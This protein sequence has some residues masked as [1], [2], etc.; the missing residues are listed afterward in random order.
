M[1]TYFPL[2][3]NINPSSALPPLTIVAFAFC[4]L[5]HRY[6][7]RIIPATPI[8]ILSH[9][10]PPAGTVYP[11][12]LHYSHG[13]DTI[14]AP[15]PAE[16]RSPRPGCTCRPQ[17]VYTPPSLLVPTPSLLLLQRYRQLTLVTTTHSY[18]KLL[19]P[20]LEIILNDHLRTHASQLQN[21]ARLSSYYKTLR[22][23]DS[24]VK[25]ESGGGLEVEGRK[26]KSRRQTLKAREELEGMS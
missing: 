3:V 21:D 19:K 11:Y 16:T 22:R 13:D 4:C 18:D 1:S 23:A 14:L 7:G 17:W 6:H 20:D 25:R 5:N 24:P 10:T 9:P 26:V 12:H 2:F 15:T 8:D